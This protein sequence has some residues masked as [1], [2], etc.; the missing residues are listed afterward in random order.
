MT[1]TPVLRGPVL[2]EES[3]GHAEL[4]SL[5]G[6]ASSGGGLPTPASRRA[7]GADV[8]RP[9][10]PEGAGPAGHRLQGHSIQQTNFFV[11][12][13]MGGNVV[14]IG[15]INSR[16]DR[17][18]A[19]Q[20]I[21]QPT[22][23]PG[24]VN[25]RRP[26]FSQYPLLTNINMITNKAAKRY[27]A[28]QLLFQRRYSGGLNFSTH[29]TL[30]HATQS[31]FTP[32]DATLPLE[33]GNIPTYD[34]RHHWVGIVGYELPWGRSL[35]GM[36]HG[37]LAGWQVNFVANVASGPA[38]TIV[39]SSSQTN[40]GGSYR[41]NLVGD[42]DLPS[43]ERTIQRWFNTSAFA[44]RPRSPRVTSALARCTGRVPSGWT[45]RSASRWP[46]TDQAVCR[47]GSG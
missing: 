33:W 5:H 44:L 35:K 12:K 28:G 31:T 18:N 37:F 6:S 32:W 8:Q 3:S 40:T 10:H 27:D 38:F 24:G 22:P 25:A 41:P 9:T 45:S 21:N 43:S 42:P 47:C 13:Q 29:Y 39:N 34:I 23:G 36:S 2:P 11:E 17:I 26:Y 7:A 16:S 30:A 4:R 14:S 19:N 15:Y 1:Y 20:N 46:S